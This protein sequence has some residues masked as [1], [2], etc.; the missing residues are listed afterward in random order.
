MILMSRY[1]K[2]EESINKVLED[3][4]DKLLRDADGEMAVPST[5]NKEAIDAKLKEGDRSDEIF[6]PSS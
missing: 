2:K 3:A 1:T 4:A 5:E 6:P